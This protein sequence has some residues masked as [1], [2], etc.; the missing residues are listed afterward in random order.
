MT[1]GKPVIEL[2]MIVRNGGAV[3]PRA[4]R[5]ALPA[6]DRIVIGDT[7][8]TDDSVAVARSFG[9]HVFAVQWEN[10]F[11]KAR[12]AVLAACTG[13]WVLILDDDEM[14]DPAEAARIRSL[15]E[16]TDVDAFEVWRWN[17]IRTQSSRSGAEPARPNPCLFKESVPYPAYTR[18][19]GTLF[20]RRRPD[21]YF[22]Y[23][24]H[25]TVAKRVRELKLRTA[26][27]PFVIHH[28]GNAED[29]DQERRQKLE[30]YHQLG[31]RKVETYPLDYWA[32]YELG[33]SEF[34][35][36]RDPRRALQRFD[37]ALKLKP[38]FRPAW[39]YAGICLARLGL[40][41]ESLA[42]LAHAEDGSRPNALL[43]E[44]KGDALFHG[45]AI[46]QAAEQYRLAG[47]DAELSPLAASKLGACEVRL[48]ST[49]EGLA[50]IEAAVEREP[51]AAELYDI[52]TA[53]AMLAGEIA[54]AARVAERRLE[55]GTAPV[56]GFIVAAGLQARLNQW[57][58]AAAIL[59]K[60]IRHY[61]ENTRL[62]NEW[63]LAVER[64]G[65]K[66]TR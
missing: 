24:V 56:E 18:H 22:E 21:L 13:D 27:A 16:H 25:E 46:E 10:D 44:A 58:H 52:W 47:Q 15:A 61:P 39:L 17:Y 4:L 62:Q 59:L 63:R 23:A 29:S 37:S 1:S 30:Q 42:A 50:K 8:S 35:H 48:G 36:R 19:I 54:P 65:V 55:I 26:E 14:L 5:S 41:R 11:A 43:Y 9:A 28:F 38:D 31:V 64:A 20:F 51:D 49:K 53:A 60:G 12:N 3:L 40:H 7:G 2:A 45:G 33:L 32:H 34:E 57:E 6:V 66:A